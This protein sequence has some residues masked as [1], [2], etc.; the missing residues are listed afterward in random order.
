MNWLDIV[1]IVVVALATLMGW[2]MG[3][4]RAATTLA[5]LIGGVYLASVY[6]N[7]ARDLIG[8]FTNNE[9]A[10]T[11]GGYAL[12]FVVV[13]VA[14]FIAGS[15]VR[16]LLRLIFLGW[17]DSL[18]GAALGFLLS[19]GVLMAVLIPLRNS[20]LLGLGD[21]ISSSAL[22]TTITNAAPQVKAILPGGFEEM[23][24]FLSRDRAQE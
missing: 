14:A 16:R 10:A 18:A 13:M 17:L 5:G 23:T 4:L 19:V 7:Q 20:Q 24:K 9:S 22:A 2:R 3:V 1:I 11:M 12:V 21:T 6:H 8:S 15:I